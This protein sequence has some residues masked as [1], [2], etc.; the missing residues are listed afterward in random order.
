RVPRNA[1]AARDAGGRAARAT[2]AL[3]GREDREAQ[4]AEGGAQ[5]AQAQPEVRIA[6]RAPNHLGDG[7]M[8]LPALEALARL[9]DLTIHAPRW[10]EALYR[11]LPARVVPRG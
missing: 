3:V 7:V 6:A 11:D 9:G 2:E 5:V 8:A 4:A 10:G 1:G